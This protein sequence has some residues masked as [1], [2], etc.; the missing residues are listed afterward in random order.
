MPTI[1]SARARLTIEC[2]WIVAGAIDRGPSIPFTERAN[3]A[4]EVASIRNPGGITPRA[5]PLAVPTNVISTSGARAPKADA[6]ASA[7]I[8]WPPVPPAAMTIDLLMGLHARGRAPLNAS[9]DRPF[10]GRP[11][12]A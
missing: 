7:G 5:S 2:A 8:K 12:A 11:L 6:I 3:G 1:T 4:T 10:H 9:A